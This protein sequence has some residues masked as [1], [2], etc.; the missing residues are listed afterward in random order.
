MWTNYLK[1][2]VTYMIAIIEHD[3]V[4]LSEKVLYNEFV[5]IKRLHNYGFRATHSKGAIQYDVQRRFYTD[6]RTCA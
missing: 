4:A 2:I 5:E 1:P 3:K 6:A